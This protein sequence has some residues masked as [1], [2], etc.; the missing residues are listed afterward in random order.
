LLKED[1][2]PLGTSKPHLFLHQ[3]DIHHGTDVNYLCLANVVVNSTM[4][5]HIMK[6]YGKGL[7][8]DEQT[9]KKKTDQDL[10]VTIML[11]E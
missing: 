7:T 5:E 11:K 3:P 8:K 4:K 1:R 9:K 2:L 6:M 10:I